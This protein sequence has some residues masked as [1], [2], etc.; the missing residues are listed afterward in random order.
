[1]NLETLGRK[2]IATARKNPPAD[3]VP[4]AFEKRI[5]ARVLAPRTVSDEWAQWARSL[6]LGAA[7]CMVITAGIYLWSSLPEAD[8]ELAMDFS[9]SIEQTIL[10]DDEVDFE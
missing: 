3:A 2:L 4:Y 9:E 8:L 10:A 1:M 6:W 7:A 5:M